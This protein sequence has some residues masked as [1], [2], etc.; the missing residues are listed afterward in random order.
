[1][2]EAKQMKKSV[3]ELAEQEIR[4]EMIEKAKGRI[5]DKLREVEAA[6]KVLANAERELQDLFDEIDQDEKDSDV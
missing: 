5:K 6:K 1:M 4:A 3:R 2:G